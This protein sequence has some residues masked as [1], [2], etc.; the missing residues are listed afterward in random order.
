LVRR[1]GIRIDD[2]GIEKFEDY[3]SDKSKS[4]NTS[5][6]MG[7]IGQIEKITFDT[8]LNSEYQ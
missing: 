4:S 7:K 6:P 1:S 8:D 5:R 2:D 3:F